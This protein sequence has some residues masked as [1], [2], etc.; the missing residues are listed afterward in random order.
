M[1]PVLIVFLPAL[2]AIALALVCYGAYWFFKPI[3]KE[4]RTSWRAWWHRA[5]WMIPPTY[6]YPN[7]MRQFHRWEISKEYID[8][9]EG[10]TFEPEHPN[11]TYV[12]WITICMEDSVYTIGMSEADYMAF[13]ELMY[14]KRASQ[15]M[16]PVTYVKLDGQITVTDVSTRPVSVESLAEPHLFIP[17]ERGPT[18]P[19]SFGGKVGGEGIW[20]P[21]KR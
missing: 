3:P 18:N 2:I 19:P 11:P 20:E 8:I 1:D 4:V 9:G 5:K 21:S 10:E 14:Q 12:R 15:S 13:S 7:P 16:E 6:R 17:S